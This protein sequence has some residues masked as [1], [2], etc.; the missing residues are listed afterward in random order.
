M[1]KG[2]CD[3]ELHSNRPRKSGRRMEKKSNR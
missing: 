3:G 2:N 1:K